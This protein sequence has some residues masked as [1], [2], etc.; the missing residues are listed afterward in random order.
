MQNS[1]A[2]NYLIEQLNATG[3]EKTS[4]Y[5]SRIMEEIYDWEREEVEDIIWDAFLIKKK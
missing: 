2:Y 3:A 1:K 4:G 5:Y